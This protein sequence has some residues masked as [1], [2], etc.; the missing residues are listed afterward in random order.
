MRRTRAPPPESKK[1]RDWPK[2]GANPTQPTAEPHCLP[3]GKRGHSFWRAE[4]FR[5]AEQHVSPNLRQKDKC[6]QTHLRRRIRKEPSRPTRCRASCPSDRRG[7]RVETERFP[8]KRAH[9]LFGGVRT[10]YRRRTSPRGGRA[11]IGGWSSDRKKHA[12]LPG[13]GP[14]ASRVLPRTDSDCLGPHAEIADGWLAV[15]GGCPRARGRTFPRGGRADEGRGS[16]D[17]KVR[18]VW[19]RPGPPASRVLPRTVSDCMAPHAEIADGCLA[20][21]KA[22]M[23]RTEEDVGDKSQQAAKRVN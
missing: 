13:S 1:G 4:T 21:L 20:F 14:P 12:G 18:V 9:W 3:S 7:W 15:G 23:D 5:G 16:P 8:Q 10:R 19:P 2:D 11:E 17:R 6:G 22:G